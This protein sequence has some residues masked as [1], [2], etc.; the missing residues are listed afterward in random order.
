[1]S[2]ARTGTGPASAALDVKTHETDTKRTSQIV[3]DNRIVFSG[4]GI[5]VQRQYLNFPIY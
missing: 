3:R 1:M 5:D 4:D 2:A